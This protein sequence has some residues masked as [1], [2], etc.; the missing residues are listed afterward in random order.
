MLDMLFK[1]IE[2]QVQSKNPNL[3]NNMQSRVNTC[4]QFDEMCSF[5]PLIGLSLL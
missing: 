1:I 3:V 4:I 5:L 2:Y